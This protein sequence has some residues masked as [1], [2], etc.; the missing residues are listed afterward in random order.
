VEQPKVIHT[1]T[2][3][4]GVPRL[5]RVESQSFLL[6]L[7]PDSYPQTVFGPSFCP[8]LPPYHSILLL[9]TMLHAATRTSAS[10]AS[11]SASASKLI[12]PLISRP[13]RFLATAASGVSLIASRETGEDAP[14]C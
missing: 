13:Q 8:H 14:T 6:L 9:S 7:L 12:A 1:P 5:Q 3:A 4:E 2:K 11:S 10:V